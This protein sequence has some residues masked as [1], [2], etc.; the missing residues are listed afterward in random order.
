M[1][2]TFSRDGRDYYKTPDGRLVSVEAGFDAAS[3]YEGLTPATKQDVD[4]RDV[5]RATAPLQQDPRFDRDAEGY[6]NPDAAFGDAP[7]LTPE[8]VAEFQTAEPEKPPAPQP[9]ARDGRDYY[10]RPDGTIVSVEAG[11]DPSEDY[12]NLAPA[13]AEEVR[14][15]DVQ[16]RS[17]SL[18]DQVETVAHSAGA[19]LAETAAGLY[20][21][22]HDM[23]VG[24]Y[25]EPSQV[26]GRDVV[27]DVYG[28]P[29]FYGKK[30]LE[31][32]EANP[33]AAI[34]GSAVP[35]VALNYLIPGGG[36]EGTVLRGMRLLSPETTA[37]RVLASSIMT[38]AGNAAIENEE[39][40]MGRAFG[41]WAPTQLVLEGGLNV[42]GHL[43]GKAI[44]KGKNA[45]S[46]LVERART[47]AVDQAL[48]ETDPVKAA[49]L[50]RKNAPA[51]YERAQTQLDDALDAIETRLESSPDRMFTPGALKKTVS[52]NVNAQVDALAP[53]MARV[54]Q[55]AEVTDSPALHEAVTIL[56]QTRGGGGPAMFRAARD[57]WKVI[58]D[59]GLDSPL[60][61]EAIEALES[62][63]SND[64]VWGRAARDHAN[65]LAAGR[66]VGPMQKR[67]VG[68]T[69]ARPGIDALIENA[70]SVA[71][72]TRDEK[73]AAD[74]ERAAAALADADKVTGARVMADDL[75]DDE[76]AAMRKALDA[77]PDKAPKLTEQVSDALDRLDEA[78]PG[79]LGETWTPQ[80]VE[81]HIAE[82]V[83]GSKAA[84]E[85]LGAAIERV[86]QWIA[87]AK[88]ANGQLELSWARK[89]HAPATPTQLAAVETQLDKLRALL[90]EVDEVAKA[91][92]AVRNHDS[93]PRNFAER[94]I[95][96]ATGKLASQVIS[97]VG[98][99]AAGAAAGYAGGGPMGA[100]IGGLAGQAIEGYVEPIVRERATKLGQWLKDT[101]RKHKGTAAGVAALYGANRLANDPNDPSPNAAAAVGML[102]VPLMFA[103]GRK[104]PITLIDGIRALNAKMSEAAAQGVK[105]V[106]FWDVREPWLRELFG[107]ADHPAVRLIDDAVSRLRKHSRIDG[108]SDREIADALDYSIGD[109]RGR[110][111]RVL[112]EAP[113]RD[114]DAPPGTFADDIDG[115]FD[116]I[117]DELQQPPNMREAL[118]AMRAAISPEGRKAF[119]QYQAGTGYKMNEVLRGQGGSGTY[120]DLAE[121]WAQDVRGYLDEA[122]DAGATAPGLV[123]RGVR[124]SPEEL[125]RLKTARVLTAQAFVSTSPNPRTAKTFANP[126]EH[127][128]QHSQARSLGK[129]PVLF[130]IEQATG[131]PLS[132]AEVTLR[133]GTQFK[134]LG[135]SERNVGTKAKPKM[136]T[137]VRVRE[138]GYQPGAKTEGLIAGGLLALG[139]AEAVA[140]DEDSSPNAAAAMALPGLTFLL[141]GKLKL[142]PDDMPGAARGLLE[143]A[144]GS[145]EHRIR[146]GIT[147]DVAQRHVDE[148]VEAWTHNFDRNVGRPPNAREVA[149]A[150]H[151]LATR[152]V[153]HMTPRAV[154]VTDADDRLTSAIDTAVREM[155]ENEMAINAE[156]VVRH[157]VHWLGKDF[158][159][160]EA[161]RIRELVHGHIADLKAS[162][163]VIRE[164][165]RAQRRQAAAA[166]N[167]PAVVRDKDVTAAS[168]RMRNA[169]RALT[170]DDAFANATAEAVQRQSLERVRPGMSQ[171][172]LRGSIVDARSEYRTGFER[173]L[174]RAPNAAELEYAEAMFELSALAHLRELNNNAAREAARVAAERAAPP[175]QTPYAQ[176]R[177]AYLETNAVDLDDAVDRALGDLRRAHGADGAHVWLRQTLEEIPSR[178]VLV[179]H[180]RTG[181]SHGNPTSPEDVLRSQMALVRAQ[182]VRA[183][184]QIEGVRVPVPGTPEYG[185]MARLSPEMQAYA[186]ARLQRSNREWAE[187]LNPD[188]RPVAPAQP[189]LSEVDGAARNRRLQDRFDFG[190]RL[191]QEVPESEA[192]ELGQLFRNDE[193][194]TV[195]QVDAVVERIRKQRPVTPAQEVWLRDQLGQQ[196]PSWRGMMDQ[197]AEEL[198]SQYRGDPDDIERIGVEELLEWLEDNG[199]ELTTLDE[200]SIRRE[201]DVRGRRYVDRYE[202]RA[203]EVAEEAA[204]DAG[205]AFDGIGLPD[206][207]TLADLGV[208]LDIQSHDGIARVFKQELD[209]ADLRELFGLDQLQAYADEL[210]ETLSARLTV[211]HNEVTFQGRVGGM[212]I[213]R[214]YTPT[215]DGFNVYNNLFVMPAEKQGSGA[216]GLGRQVL[217]G[218]AHRLEKLGAKTMSLSAAWV[219]RYIWPKLGFRPSPVAEKEAI[220]AFSMR[221]ARWMGLQPADALEAA[222]AKLDNI[223]DLADTRIRLDALDATDFMRDNLVDFWEQTKRSAGDSLD[224]IP[225]EQ[226]F[227]RKGKDGKPDEFLAGKFFLLNVHG[228]WNN[229][230]RIDIDPKSSWW[231]E[232]KSRVGASAVFLGFGA[233]ELI[234]ALN[235]DPQSVWTEPSPWAEDA[236]RA[237]E[238]IDAAHE[239]A[240]AR[241]EERE[242]ELDETRDKLGFLSHEGQRLLQ[243]TAR[244]LASPSREA[245]VVERMPG[246]TASAGVARFLGN[247]STLSQAY[248]EKRGQ[249][250]KL[251]Q[252]PMALVEEMTESLDELAQRAPA[253]HAQTVAQTYK[254]A[255][256]VASKI[257]QT[258]GVDL[259]RPEGSPPNPYAIRQF[260]LYYSAAT[261]PSSVLT[262]L[263]N[264]RA[265]R[266]QVDTL[267]EVWPDTYTDLK[268]AVVDHLSR[269]KPTFAQRARL[270]LLFDFGPAL[271]G[272]FSP[273]LVAVLDEYRA[274]QAQNQQGPE[275]P[276]DRRTQP[277]IVGSSATPQLALGA[278]RG[279]GAGAA[280]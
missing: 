272:A 205:G 181:N 165:A 219:G 111:D 179:N 207:D 210:K 173:E 104:A 232:Y 57:A 125:Q 220:D 116:D 9:Y 162:A 53:I 239:E 132:A 34:I 76:I 90:D 261:D 273:G 199:Q 227:V 11:F 235:Q 260:A 99:S 54:R 252:N 202:E 236:D 255:Q 118:A 121:G 8:Q 186:E 117:A 172:Q 84:R 184:A 128:L 37:A 263:A 253:L 127:A 5:E 94:V 91:R 78:V 44:G 150:R 51:I 25:G 21:F 86:E 63:L 139:A 271:D 27:P 214:T 137:V 75:T 230:L 178:D 28:E 140:S 67:A 138:T 47:S 244:Q 26:R 151:A 109:L 108:A 171:R 168:E 77:F 89:A 58:T 29:L 32:R 19:T 201:F 20:N 122:I 79:A 115:E 174:G 120:A 98:S 6:V 148:L 258:V 61:R 164:R 126:S 62:T 229:G 66:R 280:A 248:Q 31:Q 247:H 110:V 131:V 65:A 81:R 1:A 209:E 254:V 92:R 191:M 46:A 275:G 70:R 45:I 100:A 73:L 161:E 166:Q 234:K 156:D 257:P 39:F 16:K 198:G 233:S 175:P 216:R 266:E 278:A 50:L 96:K 97:R 163:P 74:A 43:V 277:S 193:A 36:S 264:N 218:Q 213:S 223:R 204:G 72:L 134:V 114:P 133:P 243:T 59:A 169:T 215:P 185:R 149:N 82:R 240:A 159:P 250:R 153:E 22:G 274:A 3:T 152:A 17:G 130:E 10:K 95:D 7:E 194:P 189:P 42:G 206:R 30:E 222:G 237:R 160:G 197:A 154:A 221:L 87:A 228:S 203:R 155:A 187:Q 68:D 52:D 158:T 18:I 60:A 200:W 15:R 276:P 106:D 256:F 124:L 64:T 146:P 56:G 182:H 188:W 262:D 251:Q 119:K 141:S 144:A 123:L 226:A 211:G 49:A 24:F 33:T 196:V 246:V 176:R 40:D 2:D 170:N 69:S 192:Q 241:D 177:A 183:Q 135:V 93:T 23:T 190:R 101:L 231:N 145:L 265:Q 113:L 85:Q 269:G 13:T 217:K 71:K 4:A 208:Y 242:Q 224:D 279:P 142:K 143:A 35:D 238:I 212:E 270:D 129:E 48:R 180:I 112:D 41:V 225:F 267:R 80:R 107:D 245:R 83:A 167:L 136:A 55:A 259:T 88:A 249:L 268:M 103:R 102:G 38:E 157:T 14:K 195:E 105:H 12:P 147:T